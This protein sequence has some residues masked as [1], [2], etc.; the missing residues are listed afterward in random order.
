MSK[1]AFYL[2]VASIMIIIISAVIFNFKEYLGEGEKCGYNACTEA[3]NNANVSKAQL[4]SC[5][6]QCESTQV[7]TDE[8]RHAFK[9]SRVAACWRL[10]GK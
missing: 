7:L 4:L 1:I 10:T 9:C 8:C 2:F 3:V 6:C 5:R